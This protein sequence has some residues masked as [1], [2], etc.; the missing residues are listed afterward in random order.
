[1]YE[2]DSTAAEDS[3]A[4]AN[5]AVSSLQSVPFDMNAAASLAASV[6]VSGLEFLSD[7]SYAST[8]EI[9]SNYP[10][11]IIEMISQAERDMIIE[12]VQNGD[13][14]RLVQYV[15]ENKISTQA[16]IE[17][18]KEYMLD[19]MNSG[20]IDSYNDGFSLVGGPNSRYWNLNVALQ[21]QGLSDEFIN[22]LSSEFCKNLI[23]NNLMFSKEGVVTHTIAFQGF[24]AMFKLALGYKHTQYEGASNGFYFTT[25]ETNS[26]ILGAIDCC[27][28]TDW[29]ARCV[30]IDVGSGDVG[31]KFVYFDDGIT[32]SEQIKANKDAE[33]FKKGEP[34]DV[35]IKIKGQEVHMQ[36]I[37]AND[38]NGY[39]YATDGNEKKGSVIEY[40]TYTELG[41]EYNVSNT[42][43]MF[44][45][46]SP[47]HR[48]GVVEYDKNGNYAYNG[49]YAHYEKQT[50]VFVNPNWIIN[51]PNI[52]L[53][54]EEKESLIRQYNERN[55]NP[56]FI[57]IEFN[58]SEQ[59]KSNLDGGVETVPIF[60][61]NWEIVGTSDVD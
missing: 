27:N 12:C 55:K 61:E 39:F 26:P 6:Q 50:E 52:K 35:L 16:L 60:N 1:M 10:G 5:N 8:I 37:V 44:R 58:S 24:L 23:N 4:S 18:S 17:Y 28:Y 46:T 15:N 48:G 29:L 11:I 36:M 38:G 22:N 3:V 42:D 33:Y 51:Q 20:N 30:G 56:N 57:D 32:P 13:M 7:G 34:G 40:K 53:T 59:G 47:V 45:N 2:Y 31:E 19:I 25:G 49:N 54:E 21:A 41:E 9:I 43:A 14:S